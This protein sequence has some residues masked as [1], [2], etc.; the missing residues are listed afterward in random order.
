MAGLPGGTVTL[1]FTDISAVERA[2][3]EERLAALS[4][5]LG[6]AACAAAAA[7]GAGMTLEDAVTLAL[8]ASR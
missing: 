6:E 2:W 3:C 1:L 4:A 8:A 7:E 5:A